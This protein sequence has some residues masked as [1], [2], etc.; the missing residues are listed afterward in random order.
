MTRHSGF[1]ASLNAVFCSSRSG[2][3]VSVRSMP[4]GR[5]CCVFACKLCIKKRLKCILIAVLQICCWA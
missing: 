2:N 1:D 4:Y 5:V 3:A